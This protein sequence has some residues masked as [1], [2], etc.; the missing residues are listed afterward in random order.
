MRNSYFFLRDEDVPTYVLSL[1]GLFE[2]SQY[3]EKLLTF[4]NSTYPT[5]P[6]TGRLKKISEFFTN[7]LCT[8]II[9]DLLHMLERYVNKC[10][11]DFFEK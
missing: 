1:L 8:I 9:H 11:E 7:V 3:M 10:R 5:S 6:I 4:Y 2:N